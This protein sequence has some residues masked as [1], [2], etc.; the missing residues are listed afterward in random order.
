MGIPEQYR[1]W[2]SPDETVQLVRAAQRPLVPTLR[3]NTLKIDVDE[4][5]HLWP[6]WYGWQIR[7]LPFCA[8]GWQIV[9][10]GQDLSRTLEHKMGFYYIQ[11]AASMLPV[12]MFHFGT[13]TRPLVLDMAASPG[14]KTTHLTCKLNDQGLVIANDSNAK[15][16]PALRSNLQNWGSMCTAL[17]NYHGERFGS[18][19]PEVFDQVLLDAPCSGESLRTAER[20]KSRPVSVKKRQALQRRQVRLLSS[21]F[22]ALKPGGQLVYATCSLSPDEDE[23][24]L[25]ALLNLYPQQATIEAPHCTLPIPAPGLPSNGE[26]VFHAQVRRAVRLW[27]HLYDTTGFFAASIR[28]HDSVPVQ[29]H[30]PPRRPLAR[31]GLKATTG[32]EKADVVD[33]LQQV[34]GFDLTAILEAQAL[35][36]WQHRSSV[37]A[38]PEQFLSRFADLPCVT[39]GMLVGNRSPKGFIPSHELVARFNSRFTERP[40][41]LAD[42]QAAIWLAGRDLRGVDRQSYPLGAIIL[43][44]DG[45]RRFLGRGKV[46]NKRIRNLLPKRLVNLRPH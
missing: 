32:R 22:Q 21:A 42:E 45:K 19:F 38:I 15:R 34:F 8:A 40:L 23:A 4:A 11:D 17:T 12:E 1:E 35:T 26:Q 39:V 43:L 36:L 18:W 33:Y 16:M 31:T 28:K 24:V 46:L 29:P 9:A 44:E 13:K 3:V 25:D 5:R 14:G 41:A 27:P 6:Q 20:R 7:P 2:L 30:P 10:Q 37:Y